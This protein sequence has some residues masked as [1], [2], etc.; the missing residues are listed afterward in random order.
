MALSGKGLTKKILGGSNGPSKLEIKGWLPKWI[1]KKTK[2]GS[3]TGSH[4]QSKLENKLDE[5]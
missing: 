1:E 5:L 3:Y 4:K 2:R